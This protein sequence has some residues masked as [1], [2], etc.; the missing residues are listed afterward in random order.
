MFNWM[1]K[2]DKLELDWK[3]V[4]VL[5]AGKFKVELK[6]VGAVILCYKSGKMKMSHISV[7]VDD[8]VKVEVSPYDMSQWRIV[9]RYN[10]SM[11]QSMSQAAAQTQ[12]RWVVW[13]QWESKTVESN[14]KQDNKSNE[15]KP[16]LVSQSK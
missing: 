5:P 1:V 9:Y 15:K 13:R 16:P 14:E 2:Q 7:I 12:T 8:W 3:V 6:D 4:E 10:Q 11:W